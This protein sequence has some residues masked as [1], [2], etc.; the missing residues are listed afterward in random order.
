M[1]DQF[2]A[3]VLRYSLAAPR[4]DRAADLDLVVLLAPRSPTASNFCFGPASSDLS[5]H[6]LRF[7]NAASWACMSQKSL[8]S[9]S[10]KLPKMPC[11]RVRLFAAVHVF[12]TSFHRFSSRDH[13]E[14][15]VSW[16]FVLTRSRSRSRVIEKQSI[17]FRNSA[18]EYCRSLFLGVLL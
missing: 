13:A 9:T 18:V 4:A 17:V 2:A 11:S 6:C 14:P 12:P 8:R 7:S 15:P 5:G 16:H 10:W 3:N 1:A